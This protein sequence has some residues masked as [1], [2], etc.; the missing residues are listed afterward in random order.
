MFRDDLKPHAPNRRCGSARGRLAALALTICCA[1]PALADAGFYVG[2]GGVAERFAASYDKTVVNESPSPRAGQ[3]FRD[4][5]AGK[6]WRFGTGVFLG[7]GIGLGETLYLRAEMDA[8][9]QRPSVTGRLAGVGQ[10]PG[11][12]QPG[13][14]WPDDWTMAKNRSFGLTLKLGGRPP[15]LVLPDTS[16]YVLAGLRRAEADFRLDFYGCLQATDCS[17]AT[18]FEG[19]TLAVRRKLAA[20]TAGVGLDRA[21]GERLAIQ[22]EARYV[23]YRPDDWLSFSL[24]NGVS[25]PAELGGNEVSAG[26]NVVWK[27]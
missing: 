19:G 24:R 20:W 14:S 3:V 21:I 11:R 22:G 7:Y 27:F 13:E 4:G 10:S 5:G 1:S 23:R 16:L 18:M 15:L 12:N 17:D 8:Q 6:D 25:V 2:V 26:I 9:F